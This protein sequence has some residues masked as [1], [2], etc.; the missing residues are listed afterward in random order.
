MAA[1]PPRPL[2][3]YLHIPKNAGTT[4]GRMIKLKLGFWPPDRLLHH[5]TT[6]G[7]YHVAGEGPRIEAVRR[8]SERDQ[9]RVRFFE[10]HMG[11]G[12]HK[13]LP[14]PSTYITMLRDPIDRAI[15][16]YYFARQDGVIPQDMTLEAFLLHGDPKRVWWIDNAQVR[17]LAG[18][19]GE[20]V[21][22][23]RGT[24]RPELLEVAKRRLDEHFLFA[25]ITE[26]F[27]ASVNL[28]GR[29]LGWRSCYYATSN[30][31]EQRKSKEEMPQTTLDLLREH[32]TLDL[33]LYDYARTRFEDRVRREGPSFQAELE[34]FEV[35]N[36]RYNNTVGRMYSVL[37]MGRRLLSRLGIIRGA[38]R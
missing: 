35:S 12:V 28:L 5:T 9:R 30:V 13:L 4:L 29:I 20:I 11:F 1:S 19:D 15:S 33:D 17:Y 25:G 32:N 27:D 26:R 16:V 31:T 37:P 24:C 8:L 36:R 21:S 38:T 22:V 6:L 2:L 7:C 10:G 23:P 3:I 34:R 18:H 14:R